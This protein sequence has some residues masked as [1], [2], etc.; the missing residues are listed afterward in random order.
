[1]KKS[2][3]GLM[4]GA[5]LMAG[6]VAPAK[7]DLMT[8]ANFRIKRTVVASGGMQV[9]STHFQ[10]NATTGQAAPLIE[11]NAPPMSTSYDLLPGFWS[12]LVAQKDSDSDGLPDVLEES[13]CTEPLDAD[14]DDDGILDGHED[15]RNYGVVDF[16]ETDPCDLDTDGD[17][18]Q[19]GTEIGRTLAGIGPD[20]DVGIF[21][22][23]ADP[24]TTT[25]PR[26]SDSDNDGL[27]D[28]EE[29]ADHNGA[30]GE[31]ETDPRVP[32]RSLAMP[33]IPLL[34]LED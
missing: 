27:F 11:S 6:L 15:V 29:D 13:G 2:F 24:A 10:L 4:T 26:D 22:P 21:V 34:L 23:D 25:N 7:A 18:L 1:M 28:G 12:L 17:G 32:D 9:A 14:T 5:S 16:S 30:I 19:D 33:W 20:T 31:G 8:S 3:V